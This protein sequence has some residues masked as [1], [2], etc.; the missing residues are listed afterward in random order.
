M[1]LDL[2]HLA[3]VFSIITVAS[4]L[5]GAIGF[6]AGLVGIPLLVLVGFPLHESMMVSL[7]TALAHTGWCTVQMRQDLVLRDTWRPCLLRF[8]TLPLGAAALW[9]TTD[10]L[11]PR[12]I[13]QIIGVILI[14][15]VAMQWL[16]KVQPRERLHP[17]WEWLT[18]LFA[19]GMIGY[20]GMG[21]PPIVLWV[22]AHR[23]SNARS[24]VFLF[25]VAFT[26]ILPQLILMLIIF[27]DMLAAGLIGLMAIPF[28]WLGIVLGLRLGAGLPKARL[29]QISYFFI[30]IIAASAIA[31][32]WLF[33]G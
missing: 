22:M 31:Q 28:G 25:F 3:I 19:G 12:E 2:P 16:L 33:P 32:P 20:C 7:V 13:K 21:G 6:G 15:L 4:L 8:S 5:Q 11:D 9:M 27:D 29:R 24:R 17:G 18:F 1:P 23:W 26:G 30:I 10:L 14:L